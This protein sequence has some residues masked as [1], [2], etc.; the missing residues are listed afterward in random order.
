MSNLQFAYL[1]LNDVINVSHGTSPHV[2]SS[3]KDLFEHVDNRNILDFIK[4]T[5]FYIQL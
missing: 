5:H 2:G 1:M 4:E 3:P